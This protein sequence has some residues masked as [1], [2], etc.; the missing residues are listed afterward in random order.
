[1]SRPGA[2]GRGRGHFR[3]AALAGHVCRA[4]RLDRI[5]HHPALRVSCRFVPCDRLARVRATIPIRRPHAATSA[6]AG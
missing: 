2:S 5:L 4:K 3:A 1:V 6:D